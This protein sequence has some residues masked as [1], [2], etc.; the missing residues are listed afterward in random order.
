MKWMS[1]SHN[2]VDIIHGAIAYN[3]LEGRI[4]ESPI[5]L[6]LYS[7]LQSSLVYLTYPSNKVHRLEHSIGVMHLA[8]LF[9]YHSVCN[10]DADNIERLLA[11][12]N[13]EIENWLDSGEV[14]GVEENDFTYMQA[15]GIHRIL[16]RDDTAFLNCDL[17]RRYTPSN[18]NQQDRF[19]YYIVYEAI[20]L[21][22]LLHDIGHLPYSHIMEFALKRLYE[23][24]RLLSDEDANVKNNNFF[25]VM[26]DYDAGVNSGQIHEKIGL[27]LSQKIFSS[28]S[29]LM[30][31]LNGTEYNDRLIRIF[32]AIVL[33]LTLK[34]LEAKKEEDMIFAD[35][36]RIVD[37][38][39]DCDRM[40][41]CCR[42][43]YCAGISKDTPHYDRIFSNVQIY[44]GKIP[45]RDTKPHCHFVYTSKAIE[46]IEALLQRRWEDYATINFHHRVHKHELLLELAI[47]DLGEEEL[48]DSLKSLGDHQSDKTEQEESSEGILP[49]EISS[50]WK[51]ISTVSK[52]GKFDILVS[53]LD[54]EWLNTLIKY[55]YF[56][57]FGKELLTP[58]VNRNSAEWN[59]LDE[60][61]TRRKRYA[62]LFKRA[63]GFR[64]FDKIFI[65]VYAPNP[66][67]QPEELDAAGYFFNIKLEELSEAL[68]KENKDISH[69]YRVINKEFEEW[70][71]REGEALGII[72][73]ILGEIKFSIG[74]E[75]GKEPLI[76]SNSSEYPEALVGN[77]VIEDL[78][79]RK[80]LLPRFHI[81]YLPKFDE[82]DGGD[83]SERE[84]L[85]ERLQ[86]EI[87]TILAN[88]MK[89]ML[90]DRN[91]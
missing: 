65:N 72:D 29:E 59:R 83:S 39:V 62:S 38:V 44:Y 56:N 41:Y 88:E 57:R 2:I 51:T 36:H 13:E 77:R 66:M 8:G 64:Q 17:F 34:I 9:F 79:M 19:L 14:N 4:I 76:L 47:A 54:D 18:L 6:R 80:K 21:V 35:L 42:D 53:Q 49:F 43:L 68:K 7:I 5:F 52:R 85:Q 73:C 86:R 91:K 71:K 82:I 74:I 63:D 15:V 10:S 67:P 31:K 22:G 60:L 28:L 27:V 12:L 78:K 84:E 45:H 25:T 3:G 61:I 81:Y 87:A 16:R 20:R 32:V 70:I 26:Q 46:Q 1:E 75:A 11:K 48:T 58:N 37:D 40:D 50:I 55:K 33:K 69:Y 89:R 24:V 30:I 90:R 23:K